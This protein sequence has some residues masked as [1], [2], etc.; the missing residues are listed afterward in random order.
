MSSDLTAEERDAVRRRY[1]PW[2]GPHDIRSASSVITRLLA[3]LERTEAERDEL[4]SI[5]RGCHPALKAAIAEHDDL[6]AQ[7][8]ARDEQ[9]RVAVGALVRAEGAIWSGSEPPARIVRDALNK[10]RA[11]APGGER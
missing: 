11:A 10:L 5:H 8:A 2:F 9:L 7:L 4:I 3:Q 6:R 1:G